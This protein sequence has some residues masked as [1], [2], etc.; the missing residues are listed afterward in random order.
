MRDPV[1]IVH[2]GTG[3]VTTVP[4]S[5]VNSLAKAGWRL[6]SA[7]EPVIVTT[8]DFEPP[9]PDEASA[10]DWDLPV[11]DEITYRAFDSPES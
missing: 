3:R 5:T 7:P 11:D 2:D 9:E 4:R 10:P 1:Q 8:A 6:V